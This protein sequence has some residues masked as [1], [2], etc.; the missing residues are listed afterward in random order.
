MP[1]GQG[2]DN[3]ADVTKGNEPI[4][5]HNTA[6]FNQ[7]DTTDVNMPISNEGG[8]ILTLY[9]AAMYA[10]GYLYLGGTMAVS[11]LGFYVWNYAS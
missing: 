1:A 8:I 10:A 9:G 2:N 4:D 11:G 6:P 3:P 7:N 5:S